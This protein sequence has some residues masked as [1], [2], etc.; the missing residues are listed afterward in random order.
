VE[1]EEL[2]VEEKVMELMVKNMK[3]HSESSDYL[4]IGSKEVQAALEEAEGYKN[5]DLAATG[6][7]PNNAKDTVAATNI[8]KSVQKLIAK[9][10]EGSKEK[11]DK[12]TI[13]SASS[14]EHQKIDS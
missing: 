4:K 2:L 14:S 3:K 9:S 7:F 11:I 12:R 6:T 10:K 5:T 13:D 8:R 1:G